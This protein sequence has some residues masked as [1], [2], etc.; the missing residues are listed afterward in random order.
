[1][2][3]TNFS[4]VSSYTQ[5]FN[6]ANITRNIFQYDTPLLSSNILIAN[7]YSSTNITILGNTINNN[8]IFIN[9]NANIYANI[10]SPTI[11]SDLYNNS[12]IISRTFYINL[13]NNFNHSNVLSNIHSTIGNLNINN[14][15]IR[16]NI[17]VSNNSNI[18]SLFTSTGN[19]LFNNSLFVLPERNIS[20]LPLGIIMPL[21]S[22]TIP[23]GWL[24]CNGQAIS[25]NT[26]S[27]L[28]DLIGTTYGL[29][30]NSSTFNI[31]NMNEKFI[32]GV[33]STNAYG[34]GLTSL[35]LSGGGNTQTLNITQ[36][37]AH[38]HSGSTGT[39]S[40]ASHTHNLTFNST[41]YKQLYQGQNVGRN[42]GDT[43]DEFIVE[44]DNWEPFTD[45]NTSGISGTFNNTGT[46]DPFSIVPPFAYLNYI[47]RVF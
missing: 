10:F 22:S 6:I 9:Q 34:L 25:R 30:D 1:M 41:I 40:I 27:D 35:N 20:I 7:I 24:L 2:S 5:K 47:I 44:T 17:N 18:Q 28:F 46:S 19:I 26:Y 15:N 13:N 31:P 29:G 8:N 4:N 3:V 43:R 39:L 42:T 14:T 23:N 21:Y 12:N 11:N 36:L 37:P 45:N 16:G 33:D 38:S 32:F